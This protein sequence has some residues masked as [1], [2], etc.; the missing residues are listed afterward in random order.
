VERAAKSYGGNAERL[1]KAKRQYDPDNTFNSAIP[2]PAGQ[3]VL[4]AE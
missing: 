2:L 1:I 4:A 3:R